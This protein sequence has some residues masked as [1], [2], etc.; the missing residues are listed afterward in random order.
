MAKHKIE[1]FK[2]IDE[3]CTTY[4]KK[5]IDKEFKVFSDD[6]LKDI[7]DKN[8]ITLYKYA[9]FVNFYNIKLKN[10]CNEV[11]VNQQLLK[12]ILKFVKERTKEESKKVKI[13]KE[14]DEDAVVN[15]FSLY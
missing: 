12:K 14:E 11:N 1:D 4:R 3:I 13:E 8:T 5:P 15:L 2:P 9:F 6:N 7:D 10:F